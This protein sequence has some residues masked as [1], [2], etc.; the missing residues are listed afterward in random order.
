MRA[1]EQYSIHMR[2]SKR[3]H[4]YCILYRYPI[5]SYYI[6]LNNPVIAIGRHYRRQI[7]IFSFNEHQ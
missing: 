6:M 5:K 7:E 1:E 4:T 2:Q 3:H